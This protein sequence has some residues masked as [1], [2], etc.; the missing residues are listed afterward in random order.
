M[1]DCELVELFWQRNEDAVRETESAYRSYLY[2]NALNIL[3]DSLDAE[4]C[5]NETMLSAWNSIPPNRPASLRFYLLRIIRSLA[6]DRIRKRNAKKRA[7][8]FE[9]ALEELA[10]C[11][12]SP[13]PTPEEALDECCLRE[14]IGRY[15]DTLNRDARIIFVCRYFYGD[16]EKKIAADMGFSVSK[17]KSSLFRTRAG[18]SEFLKKEG[19]DV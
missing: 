11:V 7:G 16:A 18:L 2:E 1:Q 17:I 13:N 8:N 5:V 6:V 4:E 14:A 19:Y 9:T 12:R 15:L 10:D 3:S